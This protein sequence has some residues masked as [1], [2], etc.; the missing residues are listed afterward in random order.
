MFISIRRAV[1]LAGLHCWMLECRSRI[2]QIALGPC[3]EKMQQRASV[4][5]LRAAVVLEAPLEHPVGCEG[6]ICRATS[7]SSMSSSSSAM[8]EHQ[9]KLAFIQ[10]HAD[11][12]LCH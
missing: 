12:W 9:Q 6:K 4:C 8:L 1:S 2:F 11:F 7:P 10:P 5:V 3:S